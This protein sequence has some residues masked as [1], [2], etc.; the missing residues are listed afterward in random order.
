VWVASRLRP[1]PDQAPDAVDPLPGGNPGVEE[2]RFR[3]WRHFVETHGFVVSLLADDLETERRL[4]IAWYQVLLLLNEAPDRRLTMS[5]LNELVT[6]SQPGVSRLV[7][8]MDR[9]G[10]VRRE[11]STA[12][13]RSV[14]AVITTDGLEE[15]A[16]AAPVHRDGIQRWFTASLTD[17]EAAVLARV[18]GRI[19][20]S[21][22]DELHRRRLSPRLRP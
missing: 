16:K 7:D 4:P 22:R 19:H 6:L 2:M 13:R 20:A 15:L 1:S 21:A 8:R 14:T 17:H 18:L 11:R 3:A 9:A 5:E 10:L 12:D